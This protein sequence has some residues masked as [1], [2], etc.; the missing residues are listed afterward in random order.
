METRDK[1]R[2]RSEAV[3]PA[4]VVPAGPATHS[5]NFLLGEEVSQRSDWKL[6]PWGW[7]TPTH[8]QSHVRTYT[9]PRVSS[10]EV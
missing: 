7:E 6:T 3:Y 1:K 10:G 8:Y 2:A 9:G 5:P 4:G